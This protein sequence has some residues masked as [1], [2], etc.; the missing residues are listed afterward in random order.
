MVFWDISHIKNK[1][2]K[3]P[4][5]AFK[6]LPDEFVAVK[7]PSCRSNYLAYNYLKIE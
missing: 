3:P 4:Q 5:A 2:T 7:P 1:S 6:S